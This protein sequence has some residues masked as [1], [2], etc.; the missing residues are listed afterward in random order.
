MVRIVATIAQKHLLFS[1]TF[2]TILTHVLCQRIIFKVQFDSTSFVPGLFFGRYACQ[3]WSSSKKL[4]PSQFLGKRAGL[5]QFLLLLGKC[6]LKKQI[7]INILKFTS[8]THLSM[9]FSSY[10]LIESDRIL[11]STG[12]RLTLPRNE[13]LRQIFEGHRLQWISH[14]MNNRHPWQLKKSKSWGPF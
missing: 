9:I 3:F 12:S 10:R 13:L 7:I 1:V 11:S 4:E 5:I 8:Q 6:T 2:S 14:K